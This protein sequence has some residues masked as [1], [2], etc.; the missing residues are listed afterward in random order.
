MNKVQ[1]CNLA[2]TPIGGTLI[3]SLDEGSKEA[4]LCKE[5]YPTMVLVVLSA[6]KWNF[7][8]KEV[9][10]A[11]SSTY[12]MLDDRFEFA[13]QLPADFNRLSR[14]SERGVVYERRGQYLVTNE[15]PFSIEYIA[16]IEDEILFPELFAQA[17]AARLSV[18]L[19]QPLA[20]KGAP[21][22]QDLYKMYLIL[23]DD[24][25]LADAQDEKPYPADSVGHTADTDTW[26]TAGLS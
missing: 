19:A 14:T 6:H 26:I 17:V 16:E 5:L 18:P 1:I 2:L 8:K 4:D 9:S 10:L 20:R 22:W 11:E 13:Y 23:L 3:S 25:K 21:T 12:T 15:T 24:A 7:A